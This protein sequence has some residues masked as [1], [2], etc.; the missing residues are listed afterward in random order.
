MFLLVTFNLSRVV[1]LVEINAFISTN[2]TGIKIPE[3]IKYRNCDDVIMDTVVP[4]VHGPVARTTTPKKVAPAW[5]TVRPTGP[6]SG[7]AF[8]L[9]ETR[10]EAPVPLSNA[11][12]SDS[13]SSR[14][15]LF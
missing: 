6:T 4:T 8:L 12:K 9:G 5:R 3:P 10:S 2:A 1:I 15:N 14:I 11:T 7:S 13:E